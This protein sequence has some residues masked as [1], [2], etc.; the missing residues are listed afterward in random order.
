MI[1]RKLA[2]RKDLIILLIV[3]IL[4]AGSLII[5]GLFPEGSTAEIKYNGETVEKIS[6]DG[7]YYEITVNG[8]VV[9][10]ENG[11]VFIKSSSCKDKI[12][13]RSGR[14][15]KKGEGA[16]CAPNGVS[17]EISGKAQNAPDAITG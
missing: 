17:V 7:E 13:I 10:R 8:V 1:M 5:T 16:V 3:L 4:G 14:L 12:C 9:C 2:G 11:E 6:L 15:S